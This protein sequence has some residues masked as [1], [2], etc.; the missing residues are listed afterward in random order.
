MKIVNNILETI[1]NT[2][3]VRLNRVE[4]E[5]ELKG[6][7]YAK[8]ESFNPGGSV[9]DRIALGMIEQAEKDNI[10]HDGAT[11]IEA[12][13]GNTGI[14]LA[15]VGAAK[16]YQVILVMPDTLSIERRKIMSAY[17]A[18]LILTDGKLGMKEAVRVA[19][20]LVETTENAFMPSQFDNK[21]NPLKHYRTT[22]IEIDEQLDHQVDVLV[23]GIGTGGSI[24]GVGRYLKEKN[25]SVKIIGIE[26]MNSQVIKLG[27]VGPHKVQG[28]GAGF[29][30][31]TL[32]VSLLDE[33]LPVMDEEAFEYA[34]ILPKL[35]GIFAG[36]SSGAALAKG[37]EV[38]K[39][40]EMKDKNI[41]ILLPDTGERYLSTPVFNE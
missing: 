3:L 29:I 40:E 38:A 2:P 36:I 31:N 21:N 22:A 10:I 20:A 15:M 4:K 17:G 39:R 30:P 32:D 37:I 14:G 23:F 34:R 18:K 12:T 13:S 26:P 24:S 11:I 35:E 16:G 19:K 33:T 41:V 27:Q 9:K 6:R 1:G 28:I 5:Y 7:L 8:I 25:P